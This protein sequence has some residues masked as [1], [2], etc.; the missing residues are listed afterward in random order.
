MWRSDLK[1]WRRVIEHGRG[2]PVR[3]R[4]EAIEEIDE[5]WAYLEQAEEEGRLVP[6]AVWGYLKN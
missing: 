6:D 1:H 5:A 4:L 2:G 3:W